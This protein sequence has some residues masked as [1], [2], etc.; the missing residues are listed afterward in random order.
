L[1]STRA[2]ADPNAAA[3][4]AAAATQLRSPK[5]QRKEGTCNICL[6]VL[7]DD[8]MGCHGCSMVA[9]PK[10]LAR[11]FNGQPANAKDAIPEAFPSESQSG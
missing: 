2:L 9:H 10:C 8:R 6:D 1:S 7:G 5:P 3:A 11:W 4:A